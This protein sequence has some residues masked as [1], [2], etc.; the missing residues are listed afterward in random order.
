MADMTA[1]TNLGYYIPF[2]NSNPKLK[3]A[4]KMGSSDTTL[5]LNFQPKDEDG[6]A[7]TLPVFLGIKKSTG[8]V[9]AVYAASGISGTNVTITRNVKAAGL[10]LTAT[11]QGGAVSHE[12]GEEVIFL[13]SPLFFDMWYAALTGTIGSGG[14]AWRTGRG[15]DEDIYFY[16]QNSDANKPYFKYD[17]TN[18]KFVL[19]NDGTTEI[20]MA[21]GGISSAGDGIDITAGTISVDL[22]ATND[23][24]KITSGEL[25]TNLT[26]TK[27]QLDEAGTFFGATDISAAEAETLTDGSDASSLH[28]H[29]ASGSYTSSTQSQLT[30][31][32]AGTTQTAVSGLSFQPKYIIIH[33]YMKYLG[34]ATWERNSNDNAKFEGTTLKSTVYFTKN[35]LSETTYGY[36]ANNTGNFRAEYNGSNYVQLSVSAIASD[37]F[38]IDF[39]LATTTS[40]TVTVDYSWEAFA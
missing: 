22:A 6:N 21:T 3:L 39:T 37:G 28:T 10:D 23:L 15:I 25:D 18:N 31:N 1:L 35:Q 9:E 24:Q 5:E 17:S 30:R 2:T 27:S 12:A 16:A 19:A 29:T 40:S 26:A 36:V 33:A 38:T 14:T 11:G 7:I 4:Q 32:S 34:A 13:V 8:Y 20:D